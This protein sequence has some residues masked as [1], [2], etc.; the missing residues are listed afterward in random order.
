[1]TKRSNCQLDGFSGSNR[2]GKMFFQKKGIRTIKM[3]Q[4]MKVF[5]TFLFKNQ[6]EINVSIFEPFSFLISFLTSSQS[7]F[8]FITLKFYQNQVLF[9]PAVH[10]LFQI[11]PVIALAN[12]PFFLQKVRCL[13]P[14]LRFQRKFLVLT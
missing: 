3:I 8:F 7:I 11:A 13:L 9:S 14:R 10:S 2:K 1:M 5:I 4:A 6:S 12:E